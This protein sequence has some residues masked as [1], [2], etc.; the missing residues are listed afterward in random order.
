MALAL[1][2][3]RKREEIGSDDRDDEPEYLVTAEKHEVHGPSSAQRFGHVHAAYRLPVSDALRRLPTTSATFD[4]TRP[5]WHSC[6]YIASIPAAH[7]HT[8]A[9]TLRSDR[10]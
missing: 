9:R 1:P 6:R 8:H 7:A 5:W 10:Q 4:M 3:D 2:A